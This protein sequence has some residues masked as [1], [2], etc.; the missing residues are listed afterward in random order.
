MTAAF[1]FLGS[2]ST[3]SS[4]PSLTSSPTPVLGSASIAVQGKTFHQVIIVSSAVGVVFVVFAVVAV[5]AVTAVRIIIFF[6][7]Y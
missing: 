5:V 4:S 6:D 7:I 3:S 1:F 2:T